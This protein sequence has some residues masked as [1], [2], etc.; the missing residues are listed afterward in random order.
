MLST[1]QTNILSEMAAKAIVGHSGLS[2]VA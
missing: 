1:M 2:V